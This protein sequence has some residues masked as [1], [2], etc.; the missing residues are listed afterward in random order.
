MLTH[1]QMVDTVPWVGDDRGKLC[2]KVLLG[3]ILK[4]LDDEEESTQSG[5]QEGHSGE[6]QISNQL[7]ERHDSR[8]H[9]LFSAQMGNL[10]LR[11]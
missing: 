7:S 8:Y 2:E 1:S 5:T 11:R 3:G 4:R 9:D 10:S 6:G